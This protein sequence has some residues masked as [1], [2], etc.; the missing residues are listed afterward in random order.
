M[1]TSRDLESLLDIDYYGR[2][3]ISFVSGMTQVEFASCPGENWQ[4]CAIVWCM[5]I[6]TLI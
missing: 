2:N 3:I 6:G 5:I 1:T 4:G